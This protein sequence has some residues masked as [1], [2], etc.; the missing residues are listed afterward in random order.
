MDRLES[1]A[2]ACHAARY[3]FTVFVMRDGAIPWSECSKQYRD[4]MTGAVAFL[5]SYVDSTDVD[6]GFNGTGIEELCVVLQA[7]L[8]EH[9]GNERSL[10]YFEMPENERKKVRIVVKTYLAM[11][12]VME[13]SDD[14]SSWIGEDNGPPWEAESASGVV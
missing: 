10:P 1:I 2:S 9:Y 13:G 3:A 11:R 7:Y 12:K 8:N 6:T 5:D 14:E 4:L